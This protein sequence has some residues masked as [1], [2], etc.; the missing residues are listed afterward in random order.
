MMSALA[1]ILSGPLPS[2]TVS[3]IRVSQQI[4]TELRLAVGKEKGSSVFALFSQNFGTEERAF[5][6][7]SALS[8]LRVRV[9]LAFQTHDQVAA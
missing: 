8:S 9:P 6:S 4:L 5:R 2:L 7:F 3:G 1:V